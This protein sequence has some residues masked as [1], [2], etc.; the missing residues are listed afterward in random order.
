MGHMVQADRL[1]DALI[2][3]V[4][5]PAI[6]LSSVVRSSEGE[7][8]LADGHP[9]RPPHAGQQ[10]LG[11]NP[12]AVP[13]GGAEVGE[14]EVVDVLAVHHVAEAFEVLSPIE[15]AVEGDALGMP[16]GALVEPGE[17]VGMREG[18]AE[19]EPGEQRRN[20]Q[21][22]SRTPPELRDSEGRGDGEEWIERQEMPHAD[23]DRARH[24][25]EE[26][27]DGRERLE[28]AAADHE[29][30]A[31]RGEDQKRQR[32]LEEENDRKVVPPA[33]VAVAAEEEGG[34][35]GAGVLLDQLCPDDEQRRGER[36]AHADPLPCGAEWRRRTPYRRRPDH[37][38]AVSARQGRRIT[39][40]LG[41]VD[42]VD[43]MRDA[44]RVLAVTLGEIGANPL[45]ARHAGV[46]CGD[47]LRRLGRKDAQARIVE[48][49]D[50][51]AVA[52][53]DEECGDAQRA[54]GMAEAR[55]PTEEE[56]G[57]GKEGEEGEL[58]EQRQRQRNAE[59]RGR[60]AHMR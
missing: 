51:E 29:H 10:L 60:P 13:V 17:V 44:L 48:R 15:I 30:G 4:S 41:P 49:A 38:V 7:L 16:S 26:H 35:T 1:A 23:V 9:S 14:G 31:R 47:T 45:V 39:G 58:R 6:S 21:A 2:R 12:Q 28:M 34:V 56:Q 24:G 11:R 3:Q 40:C 5:Q 8:H 54:N 57:D 22:R 42:E 20:R 19:E 46:L 33:S 32:R 59:E 27:G 50:V 55:R 43:E 25:D 52:G 53:P 36:H 37:R 18:A